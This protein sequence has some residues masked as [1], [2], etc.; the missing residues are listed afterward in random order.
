MKNIQF[1]IVLGITFASNVYYPLQL[2][3]LPAK[4][5]LVS[6][7]FVPPPPPPD[8]SAAGSRGGAASR[9]C[10]AANQTVTALVPT[11]QQNLNQGNQ[12]VVP[13][14]QVWGLTNSERPNFFFFVPYDAS[15]I[16][17]IE[18]V[19]KDETNKKSQT[20]Y[21]TYLTPPE[22][23]GII[24]VNLPS[25]IASL[26]TGKMY[27][28]FFKVRLQCDQKQPTTLDY[29]DGWVQRVN[30]NSTLTAQIKQA[31]LEQKA[32]LYAA[33]GVWYDAIMSLV[34]LRQ[35][36]TQH[37]TLAAWTSLLNSVGLEA[38]TNQPLIN[39]CQPS[40]NTNKK[41]TSF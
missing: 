16:A 41:L 28:W 11:Y 37:Q 40:L 32:T 5:N 7:K 15:S 14:V 12:V 2:Q 39:C 20:L 25:S 29:V 22:S 19:L 4:N 10:N 38:I 17:N 26:Q 9:G 1:T 6:V 27:H 35:K 33:N 31:T 30:Q 18:F 34:E 3:A 36:N 23:P 24:N 8:R 13:T 21:R